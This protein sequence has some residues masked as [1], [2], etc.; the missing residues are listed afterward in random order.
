MAH[1]ASEEVEVVSAPGNIRRLKSGA[2]DNWRTPVSLFDA[3]QRRLRIS[4]F[5]C[6]LAADED[7]HLCDVWI[8]EEEDALSVRWPVDGWSWC[9]PPY[10]LTKEFVG[11]AID[12]S[13]KSPSVL[14]VPAATD[15]VWWGEAF[16]NADVV[17]LLTGRVSFV[18]PETGKPVSG[19]TTGSTVFAFGGI[20]AR[21][22][23]VWDW[24][25][26]LSR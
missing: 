17:L 6:D 24:K 9:N 12:E 26:S 22:V 4:N 25:K 15:T 14:L 13:Y 1:W 10:S 21:D 7:N 3:I 11:K 23:H 16:K 19:N 20:H 2:K 5:I 18:S 8:G